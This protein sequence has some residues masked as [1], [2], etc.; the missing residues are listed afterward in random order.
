MKRWEPSTN[1]TV[2]L[3][4]EET[5]NS[6]W[7]QF[8]AN[9][10]LYGIKSNYDEKFYTTT[11]DKSNPLYRQRAVAAEKLAREIE[12]SSAMSSH[13]SEERGQSIP[14][15][16][17]QDDEDKYSGVRRDFAPLATRQ[18]NTYTPPAKRAPTGQPTVLGAPVD[19]AII[20][21][22]LAPSDAANPKT[23][24]Q[25][26]SSSISQQNVNEVQQ[27]PNEDNKME[28]LKGD[29]PKGV[30]RNTQPNQVLGS[31]NEKSTAPSAWKAPPSATNSGN[32]LSRA[33]KPDNVE[34]D[35][36][37]SFKQFSAQEKLRMAERQRSKVHADKAVKLND[38][39][40][41]SQNFKLH[42]PVP[43][44]LVP[45]LAK[46][47]TKQEE[48]VE[49]A[50]KN[51]QEIKAA[52]PKS[53]A[54]SVD[55]KQSRTGHS[56]LE[57]G[58][59]QQASQLDRSSQ[60]GRFPQQGSA[61]QSGRSDR[62]PQNQNMPPR[63]GP[64]LLSQRLALSQ[65]QHKAG[66]GVVNVPLPVPIQN[67]RI[68]PS[69][70]IPGSSSALPTP[71]S[72]ASSKF[73]VWA[74][75]FRPNP[76]SNTF[77][78]SADASEGSSPRLE[79]ST[80]SEPRK[81]TLTS[82]MDIKSHARSTERRSI[83]EAF[84]PM[85]RMKKEVEEEKKTKEFA[86]NG[87]I[88]QA[89]RTPPTW[90]VPEANREKTYAD[91]FEKVSLSGQSVSP[92]YTNVMNGS[93]PHQHQLPLHLQGGL[94]NMPQPG[95]PQHTPRHSSVQ[96]HHGHSGPHQYEDSHRMQLS[97]STS[98]MHPSP[99]GMHPF[100]AYN[101]QIPHP[102]H[103]YPQAM[104][105]FGMSPGGHPVALR[106]VPAGTQLIASQ[107]P[108]MNGHMMT[109]Q[110]SNGPYMGIPIN[111]QMH[112]FSPTQAHAYPHHAG[113]QPGPPS[114]GYP[115]PRP[116]PMMSHQGSQQG[117]PPQPV[118]YLHPGTQGPAM[119][120]QAPLGPSKYYILHDSW[121]VLC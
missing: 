96:P 22:Q 94:P 38:L 67:V 9:E 100:I 109:N 7:D 2:D 89:Y 17:G 120:A 5:G 71:S 121:Q 30:V 108:G 73:N 40:K 53:I 77:T 39:K 45:I 8:E 115:S 107:G 12:A 37:D 46:E 56:R 50:I 92:S 59:G 118:I 21:S 87:G 4:L 72:A 35:L 14:N 104:P 18:S 36:L 97:A 51:M 29:V 85:K 81:V 49:R 19:P 68:P 13:I 62:Y 41:F 52:P 47:K 102:V 83:D 116:A 80:R 90:D 74:T 69:G 64:G 95:T 99:R 11:I 91:M 113:P 76:A 15:D 84:N 119:L 65:Q 114:S 55:P 70:P 28:Q 98:S 93:V 24:Q 25:A 66:A 1:S 31:S 78:P 20:S 44:D 16:N 33:A 61:T 86:S 42:T 82:F 103:I 27:K 54:N 105:A 32:A 10:R 106:H 3:S 63:T 58:P 117:H 60:R 79:P 6:N 23:P 111:P 43:S 110:P 75:E 101:P 48:I 88:P 26:G 112:M 34:P 57:N